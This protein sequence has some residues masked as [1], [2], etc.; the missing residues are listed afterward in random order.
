MRN[1]Y[2]EVINVD[3]NNLS[4]KE[5]LSEV[6]KAIYKVLIG[7]QSYKIGSRQLTRAD[8]KM[9]KEMKDDLMAQVARND[10]D[11]LDDTYVAIFSGR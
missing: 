7:G 4:A 10:S 3:E 1:G 5:M 11:L 9:L 2:K 6:D 8:L